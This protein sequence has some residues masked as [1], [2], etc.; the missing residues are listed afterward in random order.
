[1]PSVRPLDPANEGTPRAW[2]TYRAP[3]AQRAGASIETT[4]ASEAQTAA[5]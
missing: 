4:A 3:E 5:T 1:M 2:G